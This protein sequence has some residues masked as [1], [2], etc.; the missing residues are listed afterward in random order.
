MHPSAFVY[1]YTKTALKEPKRF[2]NRRIYM[3]INNRLI[4]AA[5]VAATLFLGACSSTPVTSTTSTAT[6]PVAAPAAP[7][8]SANTTTPA[9][10]APSATGMAV[11][12]YLD[13]KNPLAQQRSVY[14]DYDQYVVKSD[15]AG[16]IEMHGK[17]LA[18]N[19]TVAIKIEGNTDEQGG[20]EYNLALGQKRAEAVRGA[21]AVYGVKASQMEA[22]S[23]GKEKPKAT[24][25]DEASYSQNRRADL[26]YPTK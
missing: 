26:A 15:A 16:L 14:F 12:P 8:A 10:A 9:V 2:T 21:L 19:P 23:F 7:T 22:V 6:A 18:S 17:F 1:S 3:Q 25:H 20:A 4:L 11:A 13:P 24:G 5:T